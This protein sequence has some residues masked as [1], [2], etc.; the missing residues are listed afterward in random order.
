MPVTSE[1]Y[2]PLPIPSG[3]GCTGSL[4][5]EFHLTDTW[6]AEDHLRQT[7]GILLSSKQLIVYQHPPLKLVSGC[8]EP[9]HTWNSSLIIPLFSQH[10]LSVWS[11]LGTVIS[12]GNMETNATSYPIGAE[13]M[14]F[15]I[16]IYKVNAKSQQ[17]NPLQWRA[18]SW[19]VGVHCCTKQGIN[20]LCLRT[21]SQPSWNV[22]ICPTCF[23]A[24]QGAREHSLFSVLSRIR[25]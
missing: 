16:Q 24:V 7:D 6:R 21:S 14:C 13:S 18:K 8:L 19:A 12:A 2:C 15:W 23:A 22:L 4:Y 5:N 1:L 10:V 25:C 3:S 17:G 9:C 11:V 20:D